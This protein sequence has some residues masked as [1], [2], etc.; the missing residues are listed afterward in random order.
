MT[1]ISAHW[2]CAVVSILL[3]VHS[4][5][6]VARGE[7]AKQAEPSGSV[8]VEIRH[9][10]LTLQ[11][12]NAPL[13]DVIQAIGNEAGFETIVKGQIDDLM[14]RSMDEMRLERALRYLLDGVSNVMFYAPSED[15][16]RPRRLVEVRLYGD[17]DE[18]SPTGP[19]RD[20]QDRESRLEGV[21]SPGE[22]G[23]GDLRSLAEGG[24][25]PEAQERLLQ[26]FQ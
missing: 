9:G 7:A 10:L 25:T 5:C 11:A 24:L 20:T 2:L 22:E 23:A 14:N 18:P 19:M 1:P 15:G 8:E 17:A 6:A 13:S 21:L 3:L 4:Q 12:K 26:M 16:S